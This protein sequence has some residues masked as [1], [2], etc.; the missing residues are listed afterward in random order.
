[1]EIDVVRLR[2]FWVLLAPGCRGSLDHAIKDQSVEQPHTHGH[3]SAPPKAITDGPRSVSSMVLHGNKL[4]SGS[5][6]Q[7]IKV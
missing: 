6:D 7:A 5:Y 2:G 1:M 4:I 3:A